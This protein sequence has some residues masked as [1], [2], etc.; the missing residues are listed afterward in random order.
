MH[1]SHVRMNTFLA[2]PECTHTQSTQCLP[3]TVDIHMC[4]SAQ[5]SN[6]THT[7]PQCFT[8]D[9]SCIGIIMLFSPTCCYANDCT[10]TCPCANMN[11]PTHFNH[12]TTHMASL[13]IYNNA[14]ILDPQQPNSMY[15]IDK[16]ISMYR[17]IHLHT[18][19]SMSSTYVSLSQL[20]PVNPPNTTA[21]WWSIL[22]KVWPASGGGLSPV[23]V[24]TAH[25]P[26]GTVT[27]Q[28]C[29]SLSGPLDH[30]EGSI[31]TIPYMA[32]VMCGCGHIMHLIHT[33]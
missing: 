29:V 3:H 7:H 2:I 5:L 22:L 9:F 17:H 12:P 26:A 10:L 31:S 11:V 21:L 14:S 24:W 15:K 23:V 13:C 33:Q 32:V 25:I 4:L 1:A 8:L 18:H 16:L 19:V 27:E 6:L 20:L 30:V 28:K